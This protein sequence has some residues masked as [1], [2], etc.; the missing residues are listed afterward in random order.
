V[1]A[2]LERPEVQAVAGRESGTKKRADDQPGGAR[3]VALSLGERLRG[4]L[5]VA[6]FG[7]AVFVAV[8][9]FYEVVIVDLLHAQRHGHLVAD[10]AVNRPGTPSGSAVAALQ[11]PK[12]KLNDVVV[13]GD[14]VENLRSGPAHRSSTPL[15]GQK[16]N[17]VLLGHDRRYGAPFDKL[18]RLVKGDEIFV[19]VR[20]QDAVR[21]VVAS[22]R[23]VGAS[24]TVL[25][26]RTDDTRVTLV[27]S[28]GGYLSTDRRVVV[29]VATGDEAPVPRGGGGSFSPRR[30]SPLFNSMLGL[31][32]L[33][34]AAAAV[35]FTW[36][37][38]R[39]RPLVT[40]LAVAPFLLLAAFAFALSLDFM[41]PATS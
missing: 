28:S 11:V 24:D 13:Q 5:L 27:T 6:L 29:A 37:R 21:F 38:K 2:R 10:F 22:N 17:S 19:K 12:I 23:R 33:A 14:S 18:D 26:G 41:L 25:L 32:Y 7:V 8:A 36:L 40:G 16:G 15:P 31:T 30:P 20:N 9:A 35:S 34:I 39:D 1:S 4:P 3:S